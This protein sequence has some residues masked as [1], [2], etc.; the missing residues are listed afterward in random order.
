ME[1]SALLAEEVRGASEDEAQGPPAPFGDS[2]G[3]TNFSANSLLGDTF[4]D[5]MSNARTVDVYTSSA[6]AHIGLLFLALVAL[7]LSVFIAV[8]EALAHKSRGL[9]AGA[10]VMAGVF[11]LATIRQWVAIVSKVRKVNL[12]AELGT[13]TVYYT[14]F[15]CTRGRETYSL[16]DVGVPFWVAGACAMGASV[17]AVPLAGDAPPLMLAVASEQD[18]DAL[19]SRIC[20]VIR[21]YH[22]SREPTAFV[23]VP[24]APCCGRV[25]PPAAS[26]PKLMSGSVLG[27]TDLLASF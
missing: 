10:M 13:M 22:H 5:G 19:E 23:T 8:P 18:I 6:V 11:L 15:L 2:L 14:S 25:Q 16:G 12:N 3:S 4:D 1:G 27:D 26:R 21:F 7:L 24:K 20:E 9:L 17:L